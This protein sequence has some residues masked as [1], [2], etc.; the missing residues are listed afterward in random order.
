VDSA[1]TFKLRIAHRQT[2]LPPPPPRFG[3]VSI[4]W[5]FLG[6]AQIEKNDLTTGSHL[7]LEIPGV[8]RGQVVVTAVETLGIL[9]DAE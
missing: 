7:R 5:G 9:E 3:D 8:R 2:H 6:A 4:P 1:A